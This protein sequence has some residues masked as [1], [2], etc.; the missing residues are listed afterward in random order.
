STAIGRRHAA[1]RFPPAAPSCL[2]SGPRSTCGCSVRGWKRS[3][4][5]PTT[6]CST[7]C[8][9]TSTI[10][11]RAGASPRRARSAACADA[12]ATASG[13]A[14][15]SPR[16]ASSTA[17]PC[18]V[19]TDMRIAILTSGR[20]HACDLARELSARGHDVAFYSLVPPQRTRRFGLPA[21]CNRWLGPYVG[22]LYVVTR[23]ALRSRYSSRLLLLMSVM[24][25]RVAAQRLEPCEIFIGM[26]QM[27]LRTIEA[28]R[29]R[30][31]ARPFLERG[32]RHILSQR[33]ILERLPRTAS[34]AKPIPDA[35]VHR[36]LAEY[37]LADLIVVPS[38][39]AETSFLE[40][41]VPAHKL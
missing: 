3:S 33:E 41:G 22:A 31:G 30:F 4:S 37:A 21:Q 29:R 32:S 6:S 12:T 14:T 7:K 17:A 23:L 16:P 8:G 38:R 36:E 20:F 2:P 18:C 9:I 40:R 25:D 11:M 35:A 15:C 27:S 10:P 34:A 5:G 24:L 13:S 1:W 39:H 28:G 26:S 19:G